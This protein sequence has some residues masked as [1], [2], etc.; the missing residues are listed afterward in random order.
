MLISL[1]ST[2]HNHQQER[3]KVRAKQETLKAAIAT[4]ATLK[5]ASKLV[6]LFSDPRYSDFSKYGQQ[7]KAELVECEV[8]KLTML[9][10]CGLLSENPEVKF[11][12][13][14]KILASMRKAK[15]KIKD[16][17]REHRSYLKVKL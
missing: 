4:D 10:V 14:A 11:P 12:E 5:L 16:S 17:I 15:K 7:I 1:Q 13:F 8:F 6:E 9:A 3:T 2:K